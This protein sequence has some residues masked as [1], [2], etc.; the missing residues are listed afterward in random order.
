MCSVNRQLVHDSCGSKALGLRTNYG[1]ARRFVDW[2]QPKLALGLVLLGGMGFTWY[3]PVPTIVVVSEPFGFRLH[4]TASAFN[5]KYL[6]ALP[7]NIR[8]TH[9]FGYGWS[10]TAGAALITLHVLL[11]VKVG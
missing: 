11:K 8:C 3:A 4:L 6:L 5:P 10:G 2:L 9:R 1:E 7:S